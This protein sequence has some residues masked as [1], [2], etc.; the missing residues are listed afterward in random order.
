LFQEPFQQPQHPPIPNILPNLPH[1][2]FSGNAAEECY[3]L[4][5]PDGMGRRIGRII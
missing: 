2:G 1:Q 5:Y 4:R 3:L